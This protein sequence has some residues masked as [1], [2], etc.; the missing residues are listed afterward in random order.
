MANIIDT[1]EEAVFNRITADI[2]QNLNAKMSLISIVDSERQFFKSQQGL[3]TEF[4]QSR[5]TTLKHSLCMHVV[6]SGNILSIENLMDDPNFEHHPVIEDLGI[7]AYLGEPL[8]YKVEI[9]GSVC[10]LDSHPRK[11]TTQDVENLK[12]ACASVQAELYFR[13]L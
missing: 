8:I 13:N 4:Q 9:I 2:C 3:P 11:W 10:A 5:Q 1:A 6:G 7:V 12:E